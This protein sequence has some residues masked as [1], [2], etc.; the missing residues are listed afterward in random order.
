MAILAVIASRNRHKLAELK[1]LLPGLDG[2]IHISELSDKRVNRVEDVVTVGQ[3]V[4]AKIIKIDHDRKR[5]SLSI[6]EMLQDKNLGAEHGSFAP[7]AIKIGER[8]LAIV[9]NV[10]QNGVF[11]K[12]PEVGRDAY[13]FVPYEELNIE[14]GKDLHKEC[15]KGTTLNVE[16]VSRDER[17]RNR[18]SVKSMHEREAQNEYQ[19]YLQKLNQGGGTVT[20]GDLFPKKS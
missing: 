20:L 6:R 19:Q 8:Y 17:G 11:V 9:D 5:I 13:G 10:K 15:P 12:L 16:L 1:E 2:L 14:R 4:E 3:E 18:L 7:K